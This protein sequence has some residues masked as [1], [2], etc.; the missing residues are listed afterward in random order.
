MLKRNEEMF[1]EPLGILERLADYDKAEMTKEGLAF[2]CGLVKMYQPQKL[3]EIGVAAGGTTAVLLNCVSMLGLDTTMYSIDLLENYYLD[4]SMEVGYLAKSC[5]DVLEKKPHHS[6][7]AGKYAV[8]RLEDIGKDIDFLILDT[9]HSMPGEILDFLAC[10]PYLKKGAVV[11]LHDI[12]LNHYGD[13]PYAYVNKVLFDTVAADKIINLE[14][15]NGYPDIAAFVVNEHTEQYIENIFS[16]LTLTWQYLP[17]E[18]EISL[19]RQWY[20]KY[21]VPDCLQLFDTAVKLNKETYRKTKRMKWEKFAGFWQCIRK[22]EHKTVYVYGCGNF[23]RQFYRM[24]EDCGMDLGGYIVS[25]HQVL[26]TCDEK[27]FFLSSIKTDNKKDVVFIGVNPSLHDVICSQL[28]E[29]KIDYIL[30]DESMF[31]LLE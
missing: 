23:G 28:Q 7:Y 14:I 25:D 1:Y 16:A 20:E 18:R 4:Q 9:V 30:P 17:R 12:T 8:E 2:L 11:V 5:R 3:V 21:Y 10:Y 22:C 27:I 6:L 31:E 24:L 19:Y 15:N 13:D 29:K 26:E